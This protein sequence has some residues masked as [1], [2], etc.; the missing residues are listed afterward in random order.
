M[1]FVDSVA[2]ASSVVLTYGSTFLATSAGVAQVS[3]KNAMLL[4]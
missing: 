2:L 4:P 3:A 1:F